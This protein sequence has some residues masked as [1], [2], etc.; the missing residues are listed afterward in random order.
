MRWASSSHEGDADSDLSSPSFA[1]RGKPTIPLKFR[2]KLPPP[3][4]LTSPSRNPTVAA[5][6]NTCSVSRHLDPGHNT[7]SD[8]QAQKALNS[9]LGRADDA[10]FLERFRY[11]IVASQ[12]LNTESFLG[13]AGYG[14]SRD[15]TGPTLDAP[16][17]GPLTLSGASATATLAFSFTWLLHWTRGNGTLIQGKIRVA[18]LS[19]AII[20][21]G[22]ILYTYV[23][24]QWL[25]YL[26]QQA[27]SEA[28]Q[29]VHKAQEFDSVAAGALTLVQEVELVSR[30]YR[31]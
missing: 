13:Q 21:S 10:K 20:A 28:S 14:Q 27:I 29:F 15:A 26:R 8:K 17:L 22:V 11:V 4:Q 1:P 12:L 24:K 23:R 3:L 19:T 25:Q 18:I 2:H 6:H 30:G 16:Q 5:I 9:R 7:S 31:L